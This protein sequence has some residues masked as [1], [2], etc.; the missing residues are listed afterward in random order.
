MLSDKDALITIGVKDMKRAG[1]FYG[2]TL[3]LKPV[4]KPE[5]GSLLFTSGKG[6]IFIYES[7]YAGTNQAT[8]ITWIVGQELETIVADLRAKGVT[9]EHYDN[10]PQT[11]RD[12][13]IH[14]AGGHKIAWFRDPDGNILSLAGG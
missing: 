11:T 14:N 4:P 10:L 6:T 9:F 13:D 1:Q 2:E 12:G 7:Q 3:G 8:A 5:P